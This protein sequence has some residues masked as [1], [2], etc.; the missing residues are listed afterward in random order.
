MSDSLS[1]F[2]YQDIDENLGIALTHQLSYDELKQQLAQALIPLLQHNTQRLFA[3]LYRID[4]AESK[5]KDIIFDP[6]VAE[7][8]ADL[9]LQKLIEKT[10]WRNKYSSN[11]NNDAY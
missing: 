3:Y 2:E 6:D 5:V 7:K 11:S 4:V 10:Y 8:L 1:T 9:I